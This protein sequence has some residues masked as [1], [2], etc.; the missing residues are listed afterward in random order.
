MADEVIARTSELHAMVIAGSV[1]GVLT[2]TGLVPASA[3]PRSGA[4]RITKECHE[5]HGAAGE[6]CTITSSDLKGVDPGSR[7]VYTSAAGATSLNTDVVLWTG[8]GNRAFGHVVLDFTTGT[9]TV[10]LDGGTG[11]FRHVHAV[12]A[13]SH[14][15]GFD[16]AW[17]GIF[18][19]GSDD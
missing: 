11:R 8:P 12:A 17:D 13:V 9:G 6:F 2:F 3:S 10:T 4:F 18:G 19:F 16:W 14:I 5:Y 1:A 7:V 15:D